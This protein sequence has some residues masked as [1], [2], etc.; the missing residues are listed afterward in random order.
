MANTEDKSDSK[1]MT[2]QDKSNLD[3]ELKLAKMSL[4]K[5]EELN[6]LD[7]MAIEFNNIG[8]ILK[9]KGDL[10][11]ALDYAKKALEIHRSLNNKI[12]MAIEFNNIGT[13]MLSIGNLDQA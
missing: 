12:G 7:S 10:D 4:K 2:I 11:Q 9:E 8:Q 1:R 3:E 5:S 6:D 13:I